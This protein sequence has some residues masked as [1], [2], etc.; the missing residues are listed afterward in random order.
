VGA[1]DG[2]RHRA[3]LVGIELDRAAVARAGTRKVVAAP[4]KVVPPSMTGAMM[5]TFKRPGPNVPVPVSFPCAVSAEAVAA[6]IAAVAS[7]ARSA[8]FMMFSLSIV[9]AGVPRHLYTLCCIQTR[10]VV[11]LP[12][13]RKAQSDNAGEFVCPECGRAF[14]RA[15]AL[16]A[17][18]RRAH[19]VVG[20][21]ARARGARGRRSRR[22]AKE[23]AL[24][25]D[26][27]L[28]AVFPNGI[29]PNEEVVRSL[30]AWLDEAERL[31]SKR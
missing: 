25:R 13:S 21:T 5:F 26:A 18:R 20:A 4:T 23:G 11:N 1:D 2:N 15:A 6:K 12:R 7:A 17:H 8:F 3:E 24:D 16:G 29:P 9:V 28:R 10:R 22:S 19:D 31:A 27:L 14:G 30:N